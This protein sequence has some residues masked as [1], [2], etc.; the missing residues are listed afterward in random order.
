METELRYTRIIEAV[1]EMPWAIL[2]SKLAVIRDLL[3]L[4]ASGQKLTA[5]EVRE[6]LDAS[7]RTEM[8][9][10]LSIK[11]VA[12]AETGAVI[13]AKSGE[14]APG[15]AVAVLP[16]V[17][18]IIPRANFFTE[19]SGA[20]SVQ[21]FTRALRQALADPE[22]GS[23]VIDIDSPGGQVGGVPEL[24]AEIYRARGKKPITAVANTLAASAAYWIGTAADELVVTPSGEVGSI[25][26]VAIHEDIS[27][28]LE[29]EGVDVS[30][31]TAGKYKVE[32][33]PF[34]PLG[35]EART[36]IQ[37]RVDEYYGMFVADVARHRKVSRA[38]VRDGFAEGRV[39]GAE[40]AVSLNMADRVATLD[41]VLSELSQRQQRQARARAETDTRRRRLRAAAL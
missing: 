41:Q 40:T 34:E 26:V 21:R 39:V 12:D 2:P 1:C 27:G 37:G 16:L 11:K 30:L 24:A 8:T 13:T 25:G 7:H 18:T 38:A 9:W 20:V 22:V 33:N 36:A 4:R 28:L 17:G 6:R 5:D 3:A 19:T 14:V 15:A 23:I 29:K 35:E 10:I 31:I 32:G